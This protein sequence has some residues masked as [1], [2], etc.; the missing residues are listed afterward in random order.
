M[1]NKLSLYSIII[2]LQNLN[3]LRLMGMHFMPYTSRLWKKS[4]I[5][6]VIKTSQPERRALLRDIRILKDLNY[7]QVNRL[8]SCNKGLA[9]DVTISVKRKIASFYVLTNMIW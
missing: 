9:A 5:I 8:Y 7:T 6:P 4:K 3:L 1:L 2:V